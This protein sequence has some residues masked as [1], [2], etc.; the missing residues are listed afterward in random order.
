MKF[1]HR[2]Q[3]FYKVLACLSSIYQNIQVFHKGF[4]LRQFRLD[5][6][7]FFTPEALFLSVIQCLVEDQ[8]VLIFILFWM[9]RGFFNFYFRHKQKE[10]IMIIII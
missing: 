7:T 1:N 8:T 10:M 3:A 4:F 5:W 9:L 6:D 2:I